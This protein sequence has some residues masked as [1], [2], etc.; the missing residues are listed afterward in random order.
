MYFTGS[1][2]ENI[3]AIF[4]ILLLNYHFWQKNR[5][6]SKFLSTHRSECDKS[7]SRVMFDTD[8]SFSVKRRF[9]DISLDLNLNILL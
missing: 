2:F 5:I 1:V 9:K 7:K 4:D 8:F 6:K 3:A